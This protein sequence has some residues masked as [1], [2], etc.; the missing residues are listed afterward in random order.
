MRGPFSKAKKSRRG[1][2]TGS[3]LLL[4]ARKAVKGGGADDRPRKPSGF[5]CRD[6]ASRVYYTTK[7][8]RLLARA[9]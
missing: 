9:F 8:K 4:S 6:A 3:G 7:E 1:R 5:E 2:E